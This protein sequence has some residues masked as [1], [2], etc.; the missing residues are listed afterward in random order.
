MIADEV[1]YETKIK[2]YP[3]M[4]EG[5]YGLAPWKAM[6]YAIWQYNEVG[7]IVSEPHNCKSHFVNDLV[8]YAN[9][10]PWRVVG[11]PNSD[12]VPDVSKGYYPG[13][14]DDT[15]YLGKYDDLEV[16]KQNN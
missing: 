9:V 12:G 5:Y 11:E 15:G 1:D 13:P 14:A 3:L 6:N 10:Y 7:K 8:G 2:P 4:V 16:M